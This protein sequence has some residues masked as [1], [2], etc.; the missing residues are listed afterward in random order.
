MPRV[1]SAVK[2]SG[3]PRATANW[4]VGDLTAALKAEGKDY[5]ESPVTPENI[6]ELVALIAKGEIKKD[7]SFTLA[8][9]QYMVMVNHLKLT[10]AQSAVLQGTS[11][12]VIQRGP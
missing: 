8:T 3:D 5:S 2:V 4:V 11:S 6:G 12:L 1:M 7:G 10:G 9:E